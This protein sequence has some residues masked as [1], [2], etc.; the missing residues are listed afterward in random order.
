MGVMGLTP[1]HE[2][3]REILAREAELAARGGVVLPPKPEG[4]IPERL[5][6]DGL[7]TIPPRENGGN[8][9]IRHLVAGTT[10]YMPV[11]KEGALFS[12]GDAHFAQ[13]DGEVCVPP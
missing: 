4:A 9:D 3:H 11:F 5:G 10:V 7:R 12:A 8:V 13:G 6:A 1:S 2:L